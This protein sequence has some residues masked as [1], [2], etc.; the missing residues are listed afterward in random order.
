MFGD[1]DWL[2]A[3]CQSQRQAL[4]RWLAQDMKPLIIEI[5]AGTGIPTVRHFSE[6]LT[7]NTPG[8][9]LIR[10][11]VREPELPPHLAADKGVGLAM[12]ALEALTAV[13]CAIGP[14]DEDNG[15]QP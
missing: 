12:P 3:R 1:A 4:R 7:L 15:A 2:E 10:I 8:A 5:G 6:Q 11:N 13:A 14:R 9:R